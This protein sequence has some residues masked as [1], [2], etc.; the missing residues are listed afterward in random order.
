MPSPGFQQRSV[1][2]QVTLSLVTV[3]FLNSSENRHVPLSHTVHKRTH[4]VVVCLP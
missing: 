4:Y 3:L 1:S 2:P